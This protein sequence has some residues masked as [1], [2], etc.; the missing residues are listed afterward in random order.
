MMIG[1]F[2]LLVA[3]AAGAAAD[4]DMVEMERSTFETHASKQGWSCVGDAEAERM[5]MLTVA[6]KVR[7]VELLEKATV[8]ASDPASALYGKWWSKAQV[9]AA[10]APSGESVSVVKAWLRASFGG[11]VVMDESF[12]GFIDVVVPIAAAERALAAD[13]RLFAHARHNGTLPRAHAYS[14][15]RHVAAH[16]DFVGNV[17]RFHSLRTPLK[18]DVTTSKTTTTTTTATTAASASS[19]KRATPS[20][21]VT[22][23]LL[24]ERYDLYNYSPNRTVVRQSIAQFL[25]QMWS[26]VDL[27]EF[28][29]IF[30]QSCIGKCE[31]YKTIGPNQWFTPG[32]ESNLDVQYITSVSKGI[33]TLV[34]SNETTKLG[35]EPFLRFAMQLLALQGDDA[36]ATVSV[37]YGDDEDSL[38]AA[39]MKRTSAEFVKAGLRGISILVAAGDSGASC[40]ASGAAFS[41][42]YPAS[43]PWVT[44]VGGTDADSLYTGPEYV[45]SLSG[46]GFSNVFVRPSWQNA[47]VTNWLATGGSAIPPQTYFN[48]SGRAYPDVAAFS[49]MF[50]V[51]TD[52]IPAPVAG[53]SCASPT[54]AAVISSLSDWRVANGGAPLGFL[55]PWLYSAKAASIFNGIK[56]GSNYGCSATGGVGFTA[57]PS[58]AWAP[59]TGMGSISFTRAQKAL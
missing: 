12:V 6:L 34:L 41:P 44:T 15:P 45:N 40:K 1:V 31:P 5:H 10:S 47:A 30:A 8:A 9:D 38:S 50:I 56:S 13:F 20:L 52:L 58:G 28:E 22:P 29:A 51:V 43:D 49:N 3:A 23:N 7:N 17:V 24:L 16:V 25:G 27:E 53:T 57:L 54:M 59:T 37:S 46:G 26:V 55:N 14:L 36:I 39:Y 4:L 35:Q 48:V 33:P 18:I 11:G 2:V 21:A 32:V 19:S 42:A